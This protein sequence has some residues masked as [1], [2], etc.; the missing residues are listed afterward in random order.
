MLTRDE[1]QREKILN[2]IEEKVL[3]GALKEEIVNTNEAVQ[4]IIAENLIKVSF[5]ILIVY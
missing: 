5:R 4:R 3:G 2:F 1:Y